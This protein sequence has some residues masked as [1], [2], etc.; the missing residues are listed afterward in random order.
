MSP[1]HFDWWTR[2]AVYNFGVHWR[3]AELRAENLQPADDLSHPEKWQVSRQ[4]AFQSGFGP[5]VKIA[6]RRFHIPFISMTAANETDFRM[7]HGDPATPERI[8]GLLRV[9]LQAWRDGKCD[10]VVTYGLYKHQPQSP[11][12][13]ALQKVFHEIIDVSKMSVH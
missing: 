7:R 12:F 6:E 4:G 8:A 11:V 13:R 10:G 3:V 9:S 2:K 1:W 5:P